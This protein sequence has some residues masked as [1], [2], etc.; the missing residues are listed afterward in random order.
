VLYEFGGIYS[1]LDIESLRPLDRATLKYSCIIP[2]E[3]FE[4]A[5][6]LY[7]RQYVINNAFMMCRPGHPF[8]KQVLENLINVKDLTEK[9]ANDVMVTTGP[10]FLTKQFD[11]YIGH[12]GSE[13]YKTDN[14]SNSPYFYKGDYPE[15]HEDAVYVPNTRY[16]TDEIDV[17]QEGLIRNKCTGKLLKA[18][19]LNRLILRGC[20][21]IQDRGI[22]RNNHRF[23]FVRHAWHHTWTSGNNA[24]LHRNTFVDL[25]SLITQ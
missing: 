15:T 14:S 11:E 3:P 23:R 22:R 2:T 21:E 8:F 10:L 17:I 19:C 9:A 7:N 12:N 5:I 16:F 18:N 20:R 24:A 13:R 1:D 6:F 25:S 4:H